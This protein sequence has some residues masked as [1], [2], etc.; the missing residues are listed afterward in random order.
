M[1]QTEQ[2]VSKQTLEDRTSTVHPDTEKQKLNQKQMLETLKNS[3]Y[4]ILSS[5]TLIVLPEHHISSQ[6]ATLHATLEQQRL[7]QEQK[8]ETLKIK[9]GLRYFQSISFEPS[10]D[11][12]PSSGNFIFHQQI[13]LMNNYSHAEVF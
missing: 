10:L 1:P 3:L 12:D 4:L 5:Q 9:Q 7:N 11:S 2:A 13:F 8:L 6:T